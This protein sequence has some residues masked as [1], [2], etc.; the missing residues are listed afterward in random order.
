[1]AI[2]ASDI[3]WRKALNTS[4]AG[5]NGGR[6]GSAVVVPGVKNNLLPDITQS[7][8][9]VGLTRYRKIFAAVLN[10]ENLTLLEARAHLS[11]VSQ[12][13]DHFALFAGT[14]RDTQADIDAPRLYGIAPL[15]ADVA[16]G[17]SAF[18]LTLEDTAL[19]VCFQ[20][21]DGIWV[22]D[23]ASGEYFDN[24]TFVVSGA[25]VAVTLASGDALAASYLAGEGRCATLLPAG[26]VAPSASGWTETS[27]SGTYD[28]SAHPL[29]T[30]S[31]GCVEDDWLL[32]FT[33]NTEFSVAGAFSGDLPPGE[34][35][36]D[37][38]PANP[39]GGQYFTLRAA[40]WGGLWQAGDTLAW[41]THPAAL[42]LWL[43]EIVPAGAA[44]ISASV[45]E[46]TVTGESS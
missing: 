43:R 1:M 34:V 16:A 21:G 6:M 4:D 10:A 17:A 24:A 18:S 13:D 5:S 22:G 26:D 9:V 31:I 36:S 37:Y 15:A 28:E 8:R 2:T 41:S 7:Q 3:E 19:G 45:P 30:P 32:T 20:D 23:D 42:A 38:A 35:G 14:Q 25:S 27:A 29:E 11:R 39:Q 33:S 44:S 40:G 12:G 46:I